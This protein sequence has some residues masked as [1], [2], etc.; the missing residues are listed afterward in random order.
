MSAFIHDRRHIDHLVTA[1][2]HAELITCTPD[3]AGRTLWGENLRSVAYR[4]PGDEDGTRPG[5]CDFRDSD[6]DTY[7]WTEAPVLTGAALHTAISSYTYQSCEH[8]EWDTS[9]AKRLVDALDAPFAGLPL[10]D[11]EWELS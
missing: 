11:A 8:A 10:T 5:P 7:T 9:E 2:I 6:V 1:L 4:Y 3:E